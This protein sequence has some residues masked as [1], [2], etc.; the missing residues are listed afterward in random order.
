MAS[1]Q[2]ERIGARD[3]RP[4]A[5]RLIETAERLYGQHGL[6]GVSLRQISSAAG[7]GN[8]YAVQYYFGDADG[9]IRAVLGKRMREVEEVRVELHRK[10]KA[11]GRQSD[12]RALTDLLYRPVIDHR[13]AQGERTLGRFILALLGS[14]APQRWQ[15]LLEMAPL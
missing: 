15:S 2:V 14:P 4:L 3:E 6:S 8:N 5:D 9:L 7:T 1:G 13:D 11:E 10:T 12:P